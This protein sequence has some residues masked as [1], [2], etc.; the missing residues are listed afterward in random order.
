[1][2]EQESFREKNPCGMVR[3]HD[4]TYLAADSSTLQAANDLLN[5]RWGLKG[6]YWWSQTCPRA[7]GTHI[8]DDSPLAP[9]RLQITYGS[10]GFW[11]IQHSDYAQ[12][13]WQ[14]SWRLASPVLMWTVRKWNEAHAE[15]FIS[16]A[17]IILRSYFKYSIHEHTPFES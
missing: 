16:H 17:A 3:R 12:W 6:G 8:T 1:M 13:V 9:E 15:S 14:K 5:V 7:W 2:T 4:M 10:L 11:R